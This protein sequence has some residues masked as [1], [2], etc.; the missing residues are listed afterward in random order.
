MSL[1]KLFKEAHSLDTLRDLVDKTD[2]EIVKL[3]SDRTNI[4][5]Q[6]AE[7]KR[8]NNMTTVQKGRWEEVL[9]LLKR[10]CD[11]HG[12]N[13]EDVKPVWDAIH[14]QS[15]NAQEEYKRRGLSATG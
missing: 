5:L 11:K 12:L 10:H 3:L 2:E 4:V 6:I 8:V 15:I 14:R 9:K 7:F 13:F 1:T